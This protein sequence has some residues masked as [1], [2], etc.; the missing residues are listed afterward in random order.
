MPRE[1]QRQRVAS[2]RNSHFHDFGFFRLDQVVDLVNEVVV[3]LLQVFFGMLDVVLGHATQL[4]EDLATMCACVA[5][6]DLSFL[7]ELVHDL[8]ELLATLGVH[9]RERHAN[10]ATLLRRIE[11]EIRL[12]DRFL[13]RFRLRLVERGDEQQARLRSTHSR[14]LIHRHG[15]A[16]HLD[17]HGVEHRGGRLARMDRGE[18]PLR[19]VHGFLHRRAR[20]LHDV[21]DGHRTRVPTRSPRTTAAMAPGRLT[22]RTISGRWFSLQSVIAVWSIT[23]SSAIITSRCEISVYSVASFS[24]LG[25][26]E[27]TPS[28]LVA[29]MITLALIWMARSTAAVS[30]EKYG[31]P[32]PAAKITV[33]FFSR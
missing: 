10:H 18:F 27:Y 1:R 33:W 3:N 21:L 9:G 24:F 29:L 7:G 8:R 14:H 30:V 15:R 11:P 26:A 17:F 6:G 31:L 5:H 19:A 23:F 4:L 22:F 13:D 16:V 25:S 12:A 28:T 20:V 32:V 2:A